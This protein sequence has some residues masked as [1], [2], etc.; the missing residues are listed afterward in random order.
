[1]TKLIALE[2]IDGS[3]KGTALA[4][5]RARLEERGIAFAEFRDP[6]DTALGE[7]LRDILLD[8]RLPAMAAAAEL[9]LYV[10]S[11]A[12]LA[13]EKIRPALAAG[14]T[15]LLDRFVL[16]T[17]AYQGAALPMD[18]VRTAAS[19]GLEGLPAPRY[20]LFDLPARRALA[21]IGREYD[22][23]EAKGVDFLEGVRQ[24]YLAEAARLPSAS[25]RVIDADRA[26]AAVA[27]ETAAALDFFLAET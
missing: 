18:T 16:S 2:G 23:M 1:M 9:M 12:Q 15:V 3:G 17:L 8:K 24:R 7:R 6:G 11:R 21:R 27:L 14:K 22:R 10:A 5:V 19:V 26:P 25:V 13:E 20:L 4:A